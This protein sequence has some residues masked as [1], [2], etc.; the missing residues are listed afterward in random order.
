MVAIGEMATYMPV[1]GAFT[2]YASRFVDRSLGFSM[3][4]IYWFNWAI[5]FALELTASGLIIQYWEPNVNIGILIGVFFTVITALNL[6]PVSVYGEIEFWFASVKV[7][8]ITGFLIFGI[9][10]NAGAGQHGYLGFD[11]WNN[12]GA[13]APFMTDTSKTLADNI[14]LAKFVGLWAVMVQ[15]GFSYQGTE[16]VGI[17]AGETADP[18]TNV[19]KAIRQTFWRILFF[20]VLTIFFIGILIPYDNKQ[21]LNGSTDAASSPLVIA[22]NLAG[23]SVLPNIINGVI[24]TVVLSAANSNVFSGSRI[25]VGLADQGFAPQIFKKTSKK[26]VPYFAVAFTAMFGLLGFLNES[27]DGG[28]VF[29]WFMNISGVAGFI[30]WACIGLSHIGFM[31]ALEAKGISR[32][33]L[34]YKA[35]LQPYFTW[36]GIGF[37]ILIILTQGFQTFAPWSTSDFFA[38]YISL[39]LFV[40]LYVGHKVI[41]RCPYANPID[42]DLSTGAEEP[43]PAELR[44]ADAKHMG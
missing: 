32:D 37:N 33:S 12:P 27:S 25:L 29:N 19:P 44:T 1:S 22:A 35:M 3:G 42:V 7:V 43:Q 23:V 18:R 39:L 30:T 8:T 28:V 31:R 36:Y 17:A 15:A 21:L 11:T 10:I 40:V 5:T 41:T 38:A 9:C 34:P 14:P 26:G 24:F 6:F 2:I 16:L 4:W 20:F 13:F